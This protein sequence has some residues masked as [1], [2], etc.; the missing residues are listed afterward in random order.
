MLWQR[1]YLAVGALLGEPVTALRT[2]VRPAFSDDCDKLMTLL[3]SAPREERAR[4][5]ATIV[6]EVALALRDA[7][8]MLP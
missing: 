7:E 2:A 6:A 4:A 1:S 3:E 8:T 5:I